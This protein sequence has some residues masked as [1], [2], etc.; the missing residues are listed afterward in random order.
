VL[1][2]NSE[3]IVANLCEFSLNL[4]A[5]PLDLLDLGLVSFALFLLFDGGDDAPRSSA[6]ADNVLVG[7]R[8]QVALLH[9][10]FNSK[11]RLNEGYSSYFLRFGGNTFINETISWLALGY[12]RNAQPVRPA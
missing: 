12:R 7:Y 1:V 6:S 2:E 5:V 4:N 3:D 8:K 11:L 9:S 10:E